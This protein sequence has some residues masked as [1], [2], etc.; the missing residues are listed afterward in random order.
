MKRLGLSLMIALFAATMAGA[1][2]STR[3]DTPASS[4]L[5]PVQPPPG[6]DDPG[7]KATPA[8]AAPQAPA[9]APAEDAPLTSQTS[10]ETMQAIQDNSGKT[11]T[12]TTELPVVTVRQQGT[13]TVE[14]YRKQGQLYMIR[15]LPKEGP[16]KYYVDRIGDG[17]LNR[18]SREGPIDPVYF[19]IYEWK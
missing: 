5:P 11:A 10:Q 8:A 7:A 18:D 13:D 2:Q 6:I 19:T 4:A 17:R 14:E 15:I 12:R 3:S 16:A 1:Q 9:N